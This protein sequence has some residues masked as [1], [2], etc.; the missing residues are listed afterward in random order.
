M[1]S[2]EPGVDRYLLVTFMV[3]RDGERG[4]PMDTTVTRVDIDTAGTMTE[5]S[6]DKLV[7]RVRRDV[8][9]KAAAGPP[10]TGQPDLTDL[11]AR[12]LYNRVADYH[13]NNGT[14]Q[15]SFDDLHESEQRL[16]WRAAVHALEGEADDIIKAAR[17]IWWTRD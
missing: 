11:V 10:R 6:L 13:D 8:Q 2:T 3:T 17:P 7:T 16:W 15:R 1:D 14:Y 9:R 5:E 12:D 4:H